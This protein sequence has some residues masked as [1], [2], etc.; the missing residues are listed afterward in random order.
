MET[1]NPS[2]GEQI[3]EYDLMDDTEL[4]EIVQKANKAQDN[5]RKKSFKERSGKLRKAAQILEDR[6]V[7]FAK[8]MAKEMGKP[9]PQGEQSH[10]WAPDA[11]TSTCAAPTSMGTTPRDWMASRQ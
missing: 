7:E 10:F 2:T 4:D 5:W 11:R 6:K 8:L 3:Q 1:I 9:L